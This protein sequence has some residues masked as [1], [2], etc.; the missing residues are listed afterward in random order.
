M[1][2]ILK[3][4]FDSDRTLTGTSTLSQ[5]GPGIN[6]NKEVAL[7]FPVLPNWN[8]TIGC[9]FSVIRSLT[10]LQRMHSVYSE[11]CY[12]LLLYSIL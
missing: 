11:K 4:L 1:L 9:K 10:P 3:D 2:T 8:F 12:F 6:D 5:S 7:H